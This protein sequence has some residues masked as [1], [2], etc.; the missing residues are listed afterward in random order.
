MHFM[1]IKLHLNLLE[2]ASEKTDTLHFCEG[3]GHQTRCI[4]PDV[5]SRTAHRLTHAGK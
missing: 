3:S 4:I 1:V 5:C 2:L